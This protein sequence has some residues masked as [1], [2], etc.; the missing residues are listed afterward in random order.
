MAAVSLA[1]SFFESIVKSADPAGKIR[2]LVDD[3]PTFET[4]WLEFKTEYRNPKQADPKRREAKYREQLLEAISG[5]ANN[6]G[7]VLIWG[8]EAKKRP[9]VE[10]GPEI[11]AA[12]SIV[13]I[14]NPIAVKSRMIEL[15]RLAT[16]P[17]LPNI[18]I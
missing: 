7:G 8:I 6:Q 9:Q 11:D 13:P 15:S 1:R 12:S 18:D 16:D 3:G 5:F 10:D 4:D 14:E 17:P 2:S